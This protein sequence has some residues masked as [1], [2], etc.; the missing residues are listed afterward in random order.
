M[1]IHEGL[2]W[3]TRPEKQAVQT[4][5]IFEHYDFQT[6][7]EP[8]LRIKNLNFQEN[9]LDCFDVVITTSSNAIEA[10]SHLKSLKNKIL[11][12]IGPSSKRAAIHCGFSKVI[13]NDGEAN[14]EGLIQTILQNQN[15][16]QQKILYLRGHDISQDLTTFLKLQGFDVQE[17]I[18]YQTLTTAPNERIIR[19]IRS[20]EIRAITL[21]SVKTAEAV[22]SFVAAHNSN[23]YLNKTYGLCL[24]QSIASIIQDLPW[25]G[26]IIAPTVDELA[27]YL[28]RC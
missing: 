6:I 28:Q 18:I 12:C 19:L 14:V 5:S 3:I 1:G 11:F 7:I 24:S 10:I 4:A 2:V 15:T 27:Q 9:D 17:R 23:Q 13:E 22:K 8:V 26:T 20:G 16:Q 25:A 21:F